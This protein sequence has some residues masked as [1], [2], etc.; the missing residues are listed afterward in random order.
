MQ[1][2]VQDILLNIINA[3]TTIAETM[4]VYNNCSYISVVDTVACIQTIHSHACT[5]KVVSYNM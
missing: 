1:K 5:N 4:Q 3:Q 2:K